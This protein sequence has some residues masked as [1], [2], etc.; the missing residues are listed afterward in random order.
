[1][2]SLSYRTPASGITHGSDQESNKS[3]PFF[4]LVLHPT[5]VIGIWEEFV[6]IPSFQQEYVLMRVYSASK[7]VNRKEN[8]GNWWSWHR[9]WFERKPSFVGWAKTHNSSPQLVSYLFRTQLLTV[10]RGR[11][12]FHPLRSL[13][14]QRLVPTM[15]LVSCFC[16][17]HLASS[18]VCCKTFIARN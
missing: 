12:C 11:S 18:I 8:M 9:A 2:K 7:A 10:L 15:F 5:H 17:K 4:K 1:M 14:I 16:K 13:A 6:H 3:L